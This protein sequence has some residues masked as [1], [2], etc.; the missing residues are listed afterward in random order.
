MAK[1]KTCCRERSKRRTGQVR[2][3]KFLRPILPLVLL[4]SLPGC[5]LVGDDALD[6][7]Q[8][9]FVAEDYIAARE[10]ALVALEEDADNI[11]ALELLARTQL[12]MGEGGEVAGVLERIERAGGEARDEDLL[13]AEG[14]LQVGNAAA[15]RELIA[16]NRSAEAWR[17]L[18]LAAVLDGD[19]PGARQ[20]FAN[21]RSADGD[22]TKLYSAEASFHLGRNDLASAEQAVSLAQQAAP[23][24][25]E[26]LFV[27]ARLAE[28]RAD[29]V[30]ALSNYLRIIEKVPRDRPALLA[31]IAAS[32]R[33]GQGD[34]TRHLIAYGAQTRPLDREFVY[35]QARIDAWDGRWAAVRERLQAHEQELA[36]HAPAR[37]LYAESL[38]QLGQ[39]ETARAIAAPILARMPGDGEAQRLRAAIEAAS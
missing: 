32:E 26:T 25:V 36:D 24:R 23:D 38:L 19:D 31:A 12:A 18:A 9:A 21:G 1:S 33:A 28:A 39:V 3:V 4:S 17:L 5:S 14:Q 7:A 29:H 2:T 35:Q 13:A 30:L 10:L 22:K 37:L 20:A 15:A 16:G 11:A 6:D 27:S 8:A 34:I